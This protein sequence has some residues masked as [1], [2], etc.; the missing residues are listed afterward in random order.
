MMPE[1]LHQFWMSLS[2]GVLPTQPIYLTYLLIALLVA[3]EGPI[4]T[5]LAAA[6]AGTGVLD[7]MLVVGSA[8][9]GAIS[10]DSAWYWLGRAGHFDSLAHRLPRLRRFDAS[11][12]RLEQVIQRHGLQFLFI[13]KLVLWSVTIPALIATGMAR[14][15]WYKLLVVVT[16]SELIWTGGLV[17]LSDTLG[18]HLPQFQTGMQLAVVGGI[19]LMMLATPFVVSRLKLTTEPKPVPAQV[20]RMGD[21]K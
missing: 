7:P 13:A 1:L 5:L 9:L 2:S 11:I 3:V 15:R 16:L 21:S 18:A 6:L 19:G 10:A 14:I 8:M 4:T 12:I 20:T 17:L